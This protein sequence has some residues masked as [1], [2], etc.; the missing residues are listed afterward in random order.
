[1]N[2]N[3]RINAIVIGALFMVTL[4]LGAV[5]A[6]VVMPKLESP[7][8][9]GDLVAFSETLRWG[10]F[11]VFLAALGIV[12][13]GAAAFPLLRRQSEALAIAYVSF[14]IVECLLLVLGAVLYLFIVYEAGNIASGG[15]AGLLL[16]IAAQMKLMSFQ[17]AMVVSGIG[18]TL[19]CSSFFAS[20]V[21]PRWL[22]IWGIIGYVCLFVSAVVALLGI[23]DPTKGVAVLLYVPGGVWEFFVFPAWLFFRGFQ[24]GNNEKQKS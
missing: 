24:V 2:E 4:V 6:S 11:A 5:D 22:S 23:A 14:R 15:Y 3:Y 12:G 10:V 17:L 13:I 8:H 9:A 18:S 19:L 20:R 16:S 1:M 21:I 7:L